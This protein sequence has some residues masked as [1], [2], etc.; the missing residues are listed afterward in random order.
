MATVTIKGFLEAKPEKSVLQY[1]SEFVPRIGE[2]LKHGNK[3]LFIL[4]VTYIID[5]ELEVHIVISKQKSTTTETPLS[6]IGHIE[7][8]NDSI[9]NDE[10]WDNQ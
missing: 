6:E 7:V 10:E 9:F 2:S 8:N 1:S 5:K 3:E 4:K